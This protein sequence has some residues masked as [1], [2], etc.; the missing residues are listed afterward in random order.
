[1]NEPSF[2]SW[3]V[4]NPDEDDGYEIYIQDTED[5]QGR[6]GECCQDF[7]DSKAEEYEEQQE[8]QDE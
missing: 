7:H 8:D 1:M 3:D 2:C 4:F 6:K 5:D